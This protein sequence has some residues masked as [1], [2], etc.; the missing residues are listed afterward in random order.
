MVFVADN[1]ELCVVYQVI[2]GHYLSIY[3][4]SNQGL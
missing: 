3:M 4:I 2:Y 1:C